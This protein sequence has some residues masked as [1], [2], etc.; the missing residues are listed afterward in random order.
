MWADVGYVNHPQLPSTG[1]ILGKAPTTSFPSVDGM[2]NMK[3]F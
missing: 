2:E 3:V 1:G